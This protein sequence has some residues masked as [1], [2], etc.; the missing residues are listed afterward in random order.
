M[1]KWG[2][3]DPRWIVEERADATNVNNWHWT[4]KN[5]SC[6]SKEK[7]KSLLTS[8]VLRQEGL[9]K[10]KITAVT[11]CEGEATANN[12]KGKLIFFYEW[13]ITADWT[14]VLED[15]DAAECNGTLEIPNLSEENEPHEVDVNITVKAGG[16]SGEKVKD[17][18]R[19]EGT[20]EIQKKFAD[21]LTA[22]R[23]EYAQDLILPTQKGKPSN[24]S[25]SIE[26]NPDLDLKKMMLNQV[27]DDEKVEMKTI[28]S[29]QT[30]KCRIED[31][32]RVFTMPEMTAA[33]TRGAV[34]LDPVKDG[35]FEMFGGN[36]S[37][38]FE[39]IEENKLL[40]QKWRF[41]S[42][43]EGHFSVVRFEF[44]QTSDSTDLTLTQTLVPSTDY[45]RTKIGWN[46]YYWESIKR[47]FGFGAHLM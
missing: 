36:I 17:F 8:A 46:T 40:V 19:K 41:K 45:E 4:E 30:F 39:E 43:P 11:K 25:R 10:V 35:K 9:G 27:K 21:Y 16:S 22:L 47:T 42:W 28:T 2:E 6:W 1:A 14:A 31:L 20:K 38:I 24:S 44:A 23:E 5:A 29:K 34:T 13:V 15:A 26:K 3:G 32:F 18:L 37:G 7:L 12:R 33:F